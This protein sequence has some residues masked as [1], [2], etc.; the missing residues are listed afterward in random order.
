MP[1]TDDSPA[2]EGRFWIYAGLIVGAGLSLYANLAY[3][4][5]PP[6]NAPPWWSTA[7]AW[8]PSLYS[9]PFGAL[10]L[11][12]A[13]P[14]LLYITTEVMTWKGWPSGRGWTFV[15]G[16]SMLLVAAP[17][18][19]ASYHHLSGLLAYYF[20]DDRYTIL[21]GPL[22]ID[23]AMLMCTAALQSRSAGQRPPADDSGWPPPQ[24]PP[25]TG[26]PPSSPVDITGA[27]SFP[28][29]DLTGDQEVGGTLP[30]LVTGDPKGVTGDPSQVTGE[31]G[32]LTGDPGDVTGESPGLTGE[33]EAVP[34]DEPPV[35]E[36]PSDEEIIGWAQKMRPD[37][38]YP[39]KWLMSHFRIGTGRATRLVNERLVPELLAAAAKHSAST[40]DGTGE[41]ESDSLL[42]ALNSSDSDQ[43]LPS[44]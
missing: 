4:F 34:V 7:K 26:A 12:A 30:V 28:T 17:V 33:A 13:W 5:I 15:R 42:T 36:K 18:A 14:V 31:S 44:R 24:P 1:S 21:F 9:P 19:N 8:D 11:S 6:R 3:V 25:D 10:L 39:A 16:L 43:F 32:S 22:A 2:Q 41:D 29:G 37:G 23:G 35:E 20:Q 40:S 38:P 27:W